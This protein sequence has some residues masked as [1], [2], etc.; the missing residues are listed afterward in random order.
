MTSGRLSSG[1]C[2]I[3]LA[4]KC[5]RAVQ[6]GDCFLVRSPGRKAFTNQMAIESSHKHNIQSE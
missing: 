6:M 5:H 3:E 2:L 1:E 4:K